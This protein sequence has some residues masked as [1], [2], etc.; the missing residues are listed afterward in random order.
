MRKISSLP[1][2]PLGD[3]QRAELTARGRTYCD[4]AGV[5]FLE[6]SGVLVQ[7]IGCGM[8]RRVVKL[9]AEGRAVVDTKSYRRMNPSRASQSMWD[10]DEDEFDLE[11]GSAPAVGD[12]P[13]EDEL[14]LLGPTV[15][16]FSLVCR[17]W[18]ELMVVRSRP[19]SPSN[20]S[21]D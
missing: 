9:R 7:V 13:S 20:L 1:A 5:R 21:S 3:K 14:C 17:E 8:D 11:D 16:G 6:Y 15:Y 18:G 2:H 4:L 12:V 19:F 10:D